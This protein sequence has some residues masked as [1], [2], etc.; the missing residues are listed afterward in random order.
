M[1][2]SF[3]YCASQTTITHEPLIRPWHKTVTRE[4][5]QENSE[6]YC[7]TWSIKCL[8]SVLRSVEKQSIWIRLACW[9]PKKNKCKHAEHTDHLLLI[10]GADRE[11]MWRHC[12]AGR[13]WRPPP[14][15]KQ[16]FFWLHSLSLGYSH[17]SCDL[18]RGD[19]ASS[20][21]F[22]LCKQKVL[23]SFPLET[24]ISAVLFHPPA[25]SLNPAVPSAFINPPDSSALAELIAG[26]RKLSPGGTRARK[27]KKN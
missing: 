6:V 8:C 19:C 14:H 17:F 24:F 5:L 16:A 10:H 3:S 7:H 4:G 13:I 1:P 22:P 15:H 18:H 12:G 21:S 27:E 9:V 23:H 20:R 11:H 25:S 26:N 2:P